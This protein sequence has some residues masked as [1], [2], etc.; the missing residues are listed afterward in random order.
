MW[1]LPWFSPVARAASF[2]YYRVRFAGERVPASGPVLLVANHPNSL[3]DPTLVVAAAHR[4]VRFLA[5]APLFSDPGVGWLVRAAG[6]IPVHRRSDDPTQMGRNE[7]AFRAVHEALAEGAAVGI[8][9]EGVSHSEPSIVPLRT[10]AARI[11]LGAAVRTGA[12]FPVIPVGLVFRQKDVFRSEVLVFRGAPVAWNDLAP[13]GIDDAGA[14]R[15]LT[16]RIAE[17]LRSVT[18]NLESWEDRPLVECAVRVWEAERGQPPNPADRVARL[19]VTTHILAEVRRTGHEAGMKL[20]RDVEAYR[21]RLRRLRLRPA[22][23]T[24]DVRLSRSL[25]WAVRRLHLLFPVGVLI[26]ALGAVLTWIP[27]RLTGAIVTH[28]PLAEDVRSTWKLLVGMLIHLL[29]ILL[30]AVLTGLRFGLPAG[31]AVFVLVPI[32]GIAGLL[33]RENWRHAWSDARRFLRLRSRT[34]LVAAL[35]ERQR[36]L[37]ARLEAVFSAFNVR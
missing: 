14:V 3:L 5:K 25:G 16:D 9:P 34:S 10:G 31:L 33:I 19:E 24:A 29:W 15:Q 6:A 21:R 13:C 35:R 18:L 23:L 1:L 28:L 7:D 2:I 30:L 20:A 27:Y 12:S 37:N 26:A 8:F 22:D 11:A 17:S 32:T 36:D 4:P